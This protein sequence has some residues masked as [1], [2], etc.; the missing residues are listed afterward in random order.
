M[1]HQGT[2]SWRDRQQG[3]DPASEVGGRHLPV[4]PG[5]SRK[6]L[7]SAGARLGIGSMTNPRTDFR[8][9]YIRRLHLLVGFD[10]VQLAYRQPGHRSSTAR[11]P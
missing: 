1:R 3:S 9:D 7:P 10:V 2:T 11:T 6:T 4:T 8:A 5:G